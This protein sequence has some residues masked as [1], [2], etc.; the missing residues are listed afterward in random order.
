MLH[1]LDLGVERLELFR[2]RVQL[3]APDVR[4]R[5]DDLPLQVALI[6]HVEIHQSQRAHS[7][8]GQVKRKR[9]AQSA[10]SYAQHARG[11]QLALALLAHLGQDQ[12]ARVA[13]QFV[14]GQFGQ[15]H[16][17]GCSSHGFSLPFTIRIHAL[18]LYQLRALPFRLLSGERV[19]NRVSQR[20]EFMRSE[21]WH[22]PA[23]EGTIESVSP[24]ETAVASF[25]G[26]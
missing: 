21:T 23:I 6:H 10:G 15:F 14:L 17:Y 5:V 13:R 19:G 1:D 11:F 20:N 12:V 25:S 4:R 24:A 3:L 26:R 8:C 18:N 7:G 16:R 22:P 2:G 9:R